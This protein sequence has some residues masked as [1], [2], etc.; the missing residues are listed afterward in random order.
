M[1]K[2]KIWSMMFFV[3]MI[4]AALTACDN[5]AKQQQPVN[6]DKTKQDSITRVKAAEERARLAFEDS[7]AIYAWGDAQFGMSKKEV[8]KTAAF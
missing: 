8:L 6:A 7:V 4:M 1:K 3:G 2:I 5:K